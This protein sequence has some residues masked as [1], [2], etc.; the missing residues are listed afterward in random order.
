MKK[1]LEVSARSWSAFFLCALTA[2]AALAAAPRHKAKA[3]V[4]TGPVLLVS[5]NASGAEGNALSLYPSISGGGRY[6]A[7]ESEADNLIPGASGLHIYRKDVASGEISLCSAS[8]EGVEGNS[9]SYLPSISADGTYVAFQSYSSNL[10]PGHPTTHLQVFRKD[11]VTGEVMLCSARSD[12][13]QGNSNSFNP[14]ISADGRYVAFSSISDNLIPSAAIS[15]QQ[16][17]RKDLATGEIVLVSSSLQGTKGDGVSSFPSINSDGRYI[18][19]ESEADNLVPGVSSAFSQVYRKDVVSG[20]I[21]LA[22]SSSAGSQGNGESAHP[23]ISADGR[24][25]AFKS[26][27][28]NL[29]PGVS[30]GRQHAYRKDLQSGAVNLCSSTVAGAQGNDHSCINDGPSIS[31]DGAYVSFET[32]ATNLSSFIVSGKNAIVRK[33]VIDGE[34]SCC[35]VSASG[36]A[37]NG[38]S[39][40]CDI[41]SDGRFVAFDSRAT[42]LIDGETTSDQQIFRKEL[43]HETSF[44]FAE[45]YTGAGFQEYLC[46]GN[47]G[48]ADIDVSYSYIFPDGP[49]QYGTLRVPAGSRVTVDVN[50]TVGAGREVSIAVS[51]ADP[52]SAERPMY[53][54]YGSGWTGGHD[55]L[56]APRTNTSFYFAE[57]YTGPGFEQWVCVL[58]P[59]GADA[60][61][62]FRFQTQEEGE[63][64]KTGY[65]VP[66]NSRRTF[67]V[68]EVLGAGYQNS[69]QLSSDQ[70]IVAERPIYFEYGGTAGYDWTGGH[71]VMG[72]DYLKRE[73]Y[74][75]EGYTGPGFEEWLTL[76]NPNPLAVLVTAVYQF[77]DGATPLKIDYSIPAGTR[78]TVFVPDEVG[79][80]RDVSVKLICDSPF[81]AERPMYFRYSG[82]GGYGWTGG[83]CVIGAS[84]RRKDLFFAEGYTGPGFEEWLCIQNPGAATAHLRIT[85]YTQ[86]EGKLEERYVDVASASR[87]TL[88]VNAHAGPGYQLSSRVEVTSGSWII[89]ER[90]MYFNYN[91]WTGGHDVVGYGL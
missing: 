45:G 91:G 26:E 74:F 3:A 10:I 72:T 16:I 56:G 65:T 24:F 75:A 84:F 44:Y 73:Y 62:D 33:H 27:S 51:S 61:L 23:D 77:G 25:V 76:Q 48:G 12:G 57:G 47:P 9:S 89:V 42:N 52:F 32:K 6:V 87:M 63:V 71:C 15:G 66:A 83:H 41:S 22:S 4:D 81:L 5:R 21:M 58:N 49:V 67:K 60:S 64:L 14:S 46:L 13:V 88:N 18:A 85:Y 17:Y 37:A 2:L 20:K 1:T 50:S 40:S 70:P 29:T 7:F 30:V 82:T 54:D 38:S 69:L 79:L 80:N 55:A 8:G 68:N 90:P 35:S 31:A 28:G 34:V 11:L 59:G 19:F 86:E 78:K 36:Q 39:F 43:P 53:F